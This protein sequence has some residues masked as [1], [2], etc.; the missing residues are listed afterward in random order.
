MKHT[1]L[2][3]ALAAA[4]LVGISGCMGGLRMAHQYDMADAHDAQKAP[5]IVK[6]LAGFNPAM[7][8][9]TLS[10]R[11]ASRKGLKL[12]VLQASITIQGEGDK[13]REVS[14]ESSR[15]GNWVHTTRE[16]KLVKGLKVPPAIGH[17][18]AAMYR[19]ALET[20]L[21]SQGFHLVPFEAIAAT[22]AYQQAYGAL[23]TYE[24]QVP[25]K[26]TGMLMHLF[27]GWSTFAAP[28]MKARAPQD[29]TKV[30]GAPLF[31]P[32]EALKA[33]RQ[34][35]GQDVIFVSAA[36]TILNHDVQTQTKTADVHQT[37]ARAWHDYQR[38]GH[39]TPNG[40]VTL[41]D[42]DF[43]G[44]GPGGVGVMAGTLDASFKRAPRPDFIKKAA[45]DWE[46]RWA[47]FAGDAEKVYG[48]MGMA[49]AATLHEY[50][51]PPAQK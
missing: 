44:V 31:V 14:F 10:E 47:D 42:P 16:Y 5:A 18:V 34:E 9:P 45:D 22:K 20:Q 37:S 48:L 17:A 36:G 3:V 1:Q 28:G 38:Q 27:A 29:L 51:F 12:A 41:F 7:G 19:E 49:M 4:A 30:N 50:A 8:L 35:L 46:V 39:F 15:A 33:I 43:V 2:A 25:E 26:Q 21:K 11:F 40:F 23:P 32:A 13:M 6:D 24:T